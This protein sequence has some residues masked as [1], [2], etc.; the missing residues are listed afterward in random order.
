[1]YADDTLLASHHCSNLRQLLAAVVGEGRK[2]GLE[3]NWEKTVHMRISTDGAITSRSGEHI[4][5]VRD[6]MYLGSF[7]SCDGEVATDLSRRLRETS[8]IF[9]HMHR[10]WSRTSV[11]KKRKHNIYDICVLN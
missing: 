2:Y 9:K 6:A 3:L 4:K 1:M 5:A 7:V 10:I 8:R 11:G